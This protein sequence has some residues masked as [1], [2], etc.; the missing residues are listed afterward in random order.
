MRLE[1]SLAR[2]MTGMILV[3]GG[4]FGLNALALS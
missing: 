3:V 4:Y 1:R 2:A